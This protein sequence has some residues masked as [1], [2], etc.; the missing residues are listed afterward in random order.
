MSRR[1]KGFTLLEVLLSG[2][3]LFLVI[4]SVAQ[5]YQGAL[6]SSGKAEEA[7]SV[8]AAVPMIRALVSDAVTASRVLAGQGTY[9]ELSY[10]WTA[11]MTYKGLPS[12]LVLDENPD[13]VYYLWD[14]RLQVSKN[15]S[16]R[17]FYFRELST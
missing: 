2:F 12:K 16:V 3:I 8:T 5:I 15:G 4:T 17:K 13:I 14:I 1:E 11:T 9:G 6:L 7:I 10:I